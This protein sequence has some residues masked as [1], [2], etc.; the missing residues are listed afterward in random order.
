[1]K[2]CYR[3]LFL[4]GKSVRLWYTQLRVELLVTNF[5]TKDMNRKWTLLLA[6]MISMSGII[7]AQEIAY[8]EDGRRVIL[9]PNH[10]WEYMRD[11]D[12]RIPD[13]ER[14]IYQAIDRTMVDSRYCEVRTQDRNAGSN[15]DIIVDGVVRFE[16][17]NGV[18]SKWEVINSYER[19]Y[20]RYSG[21]MD[22]AGNF[23]VKY[24]FFDDKLEKVGPYEIKYDFGS[25][26]VSKIGKYEIKYNFFND[27]IEQIGGVRI[28]YGAFHEQISE[29]TGKSPGLIIF[30]Y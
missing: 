30:L 27:K 9:Y 5:N 16:L 3:A 23:D 20:D 8:T 21:K 6:L 13:S 25:D 19:R 29:I 2:I 26:R 17:R 28:K 24:S 11:G 1:M 10:T 7:H 14:W 18:L 15:A 4:G 22:R 12:I